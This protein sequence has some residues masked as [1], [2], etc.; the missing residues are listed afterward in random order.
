MSSPTP[1]K[2]A[3]LYAILKNQSIAKTIHN[4][5]TSG[6]STKI[7]AMRRYA[8]ETY[9]LGL[10]GYIQSL[11]N[12]IEDSVVQDA[13]TT[14]L[15]LPYGCVL[16]YQYTA[17]LTLASIILPYLV[18]TRGFSLDV[19]RV[20]TPPSDWIFPSTYTSTVEITLD[21]LLLDAD[22][23]TAHIVYK[24]HVFTSSYEYSGGES[25]DW[26]WVYTDVPTEEYDEYYTEDFTIPAGF[27][28]G[29]EYLVAGYYELDAA[30]EITPTTHTWYYAINSNLYPE[31]S[32]TPIDESLN[33]AYPVVP[34]RY[35]NVNIG[36][37]NEPEIYS[38]GSVLLKKIGLSFD[39][40][41][42]TLE[43]SPYIDDIDHAYIM[44]GVDL[45]TD[46][47]LLLNYLNDFFHYLHTNSQ[48]TLWD[49]LSEVS[50]S[51]TTSSKTSYFNFGSALSNS[52]VS[53]DSNVHEIFGSS[54]TSNST[55][56]NPA[57]S[58]TLTEYGLNIT[59][60]YDRVVSV[61]LSG[62]LNNT[63][64]APKEFIINY[65]YETLEQGD[66]APSREIKTTN[67]VLILRKQLTTGTYREVKVYNLVH[68]N[69]AIYDGKSVITTIEDVS[70]DVDNHNFVIP[71]HHTVIQQMHLTVR[72]S[73]YE[74]TLILVINSYDR[75]SLKWYET[76]AFQFVVAVAGM[77]IMATSGANF[78]TAFSAA[79]TS[80]VLIA[81][82]YD[83]ILIPALIG[84]VAV[85]AID[86]VGPEI[87]MAFVAAVCL[88]GSPLNMLNIPIEM[89]AITASRFLAFSISLAKASTEA[90][91][92]EVQDIVKEQEEFT[93]YAETQWEELQEQID[94]LA[95][96]NLLSFSL[97]DYP[98][99]Y[100][101]P[102]VKTKPDEF[103]DKTHIGNPG[104]Y[105]LDVIENYV[106][107]SLL[108]P[109]PNTIS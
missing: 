81:L 78:L 79:T 107:I 56:I 95:P 80:T 48:A 46:E 74:N 59:L 1:V 35:R 71:L 5:T 101:K 47:L 16:K 58:M 41:T 105:S 89:A 14:N 53:V 109:E 29:Q 11:G 102:N 99:A 84:Q 20:G 33:N 3:V 55:I 75:V 64:I 22:Q 36:P 34:I 31:L 51:G 26:I 104:V 27:R 91:Q 69:N 42:D 30:Y 12:K 93:E 76:G 15:S 65:S 32:V 85:M 45:Q 67:T 25:G 98:T 77:Y 57:D 60:S 72:E 94:L 97:L 62:V 23:Q 38:T 90:L 108:L 92:E 37:T 9:S 88:F 103:Y 40:L 44:F 28:F 21:D 52:G 83:S 6:L 49:K 19:N 96:T 24:A 17:P 43:E 50:A 86:I 66:S 61:V 106:N 70:D 68:R 39:T 8:E 2:D 18:S 87:G 100:P 73:F 4:T 63:T 13:I 82:L 7:P 54:E 10:P